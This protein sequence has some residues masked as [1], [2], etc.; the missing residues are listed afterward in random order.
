MDN[1]TTAVVSPTHL[2]S[3]PATSGVPSCFGRGYRPDTPFDTIW[4]PDEETAQHQTCA[5][6]SW[7]ARCTTL[8]R[9]TLEREHNLLLTRW[10]DAFYEAH[11]G[12][13]V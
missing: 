1:A 9:L 7:F 11:S 12:Y 2:P 10:L 4:D 8:Q 5:Q 6:C 3:E 13:P